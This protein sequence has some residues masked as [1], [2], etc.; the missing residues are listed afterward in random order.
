MSDAEAKQMAR[1]TLCAWAGRARDRG[2]SALEWE[3][4]V[5]DSTLR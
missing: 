4:A 5:A 2:L 1:K 3:E